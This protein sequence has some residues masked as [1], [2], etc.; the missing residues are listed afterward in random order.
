MEIKKFFVPDR[1]LDFVSFDFGPTRHVVEGM[2]RN[3]AFVAPEASTGTTQ[4]TVTDKRD[5]QRT[6]RD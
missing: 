4:I 5:Q 1:I 2:L 6:G 3:I